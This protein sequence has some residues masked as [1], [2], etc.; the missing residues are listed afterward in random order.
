LKELKEL[1]V[2]YTRVGPRALAILLTP[3]T[4]PLQT[5]KSLCTFSN[6]GHSGEN[7]AIF[8]IEVIREYRFKD[9]LRYFVCDN[10]GSNN[11]YIDHILQK[12]SRNLPLTN[13]QIEDHAAGV[14]Y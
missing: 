11:V 14:T 6:R 10:A 2:I 5:G 12:Y 9:R 3:Q 13:V 4:L 1:K 8:L 7:M